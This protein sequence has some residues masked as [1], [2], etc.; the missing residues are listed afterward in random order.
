M[1]VGYGRWRRVNGSR[2]K[3]RRHDSKHRRLVNG[4]T[5]STKPS[6]L[7]SLD[8]RLR[9][10]AAKVPTTL[11]DELWVFPPLPNRELACEFLVLVCYDGGADR[12]RILTAHVDAQRSD[13]ESDDLEWVQRLRE[14]GT[15]PHAWVAH[16][17][18]RLLKRLSEAGVPEVIEVGGHSDAWDEAVSRFENGN[19]NGNGAGRA[20]DPTQV[21]N[22]LITG[23]TFSTIDET[24][25]SG[26]AVDP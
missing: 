6:R 21:D 3:D 10:I 23:I 24:V 19:G 25:V 7:L 8:L 18:D 16:M 5:G 2:K 17:P 11:I 13:P 26:F 9:A 12:R 4:V 15:A 1:D 22:G 20:V 14:H